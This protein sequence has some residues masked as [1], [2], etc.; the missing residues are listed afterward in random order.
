MNGPRDVIAPGE[1]IASAPYPIDAE[2]ERAY[3][4]AIAE[5]AAH[6][7]RPANIHNDHAR[8]R[9]AGFSAPIVA[10]EQVYAMLAMF[11]ADRFGI[12][13]MRGGALDAVF[14]KPVLCGDD[15]RAHARLMRSGED[16][17]ELEVWVDNQR[18]ERVVIGTA[19]IRP[20]DRRG[21]KAETER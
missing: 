18:G 15:L 14:V 21:A 16:A 19:H 7:Q 12:G 2:C 17:S 9:E 11:L 8:A 20:P 6:R 4:R 1:V 3:L 13:F 10:G 5:P